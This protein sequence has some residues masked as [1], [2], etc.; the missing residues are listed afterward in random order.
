MTDYTLLRS[1]RKT[2]AIHIREGRV[3][4]RAPRHMPQH[5]IDMFVASKEKWIQDKLRQQH[6]S[7]A[8][9]EAESFVYG[10]RLRYR[11][12]SYP[13]VA[14]EGSRLGFDEDCFYL[15][16]HL[17]PAQIE[18][19]CEHIYRF[20]AKRVLPERVRFFAKQ[21]GAEPAAIKVNGAKSRWGSCSNKKNLNFS[22]RL[23]RADDEIIDYVIVHELAHLYEMNHSPR[24]W[25]IVE[26]VL[27]DYKARRKQ[28]KLI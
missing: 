2:V 22:W 21:M 12:N 24:F 4:L 23:L 19:A 10:G 1:E 16:P 27:P 6:E 20:L 18:A 11:G 14:R 7:M 15:P 28:L 25:A 26:A 5:A 8:Q 17:S 3:E 9:K 13:I